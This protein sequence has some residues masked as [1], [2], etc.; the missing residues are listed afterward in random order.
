M[1]AWRI[2]CWFWVLFWLALTLVIPFAFLL[3]LIS[4]GIALIPVGR[5][6]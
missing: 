5:R 6:A 1:T 2:W 3:A 4:V